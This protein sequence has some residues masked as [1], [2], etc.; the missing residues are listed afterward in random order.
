MFTVRIINRISLHNCVLKSQFPLTKSVMNP[1]G[2]LNTKWET[3]CLR[4][5]GKL[6]LAGSVI[7]DNQMYLRR[8]YE[9]NSS[10]FRFLWRHGCSC[11][12]CCVGISAFAT[13]WSLIQGSPTLCM[14]MCIY[15]CVC[16][17][18]YSFV[19]SRNLGGLDPIWAVTPER[20]RE[21][22]RRYN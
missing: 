22:E 7:K 16:M 19:W 8:I 3:L 6:N 11:L 1:H 17:C 21:G 13:S 20:E 14:S 2:L 12:V 10:G 4:D 9:K 15:V 5:H 18:M